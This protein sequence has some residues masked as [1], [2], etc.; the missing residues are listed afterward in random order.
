ME[1][2]LHEQY[3]YARRRIKQK[4]RL[5]YHFVLFVLGSL[6]LFVAHKFLN[7]TVVTDWYL[8]IITIWLF[9]FILHFIKIFITDRFMNKDWEREQIDRLVTLQKKK[10][11]QLQTQ[12]TND[13][14]KQ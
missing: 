7:S 9:L 8:W 12:I 2:E 6:L 5:Y 14:L 10:M 1:K 11:E 13:E 3:E 4:K